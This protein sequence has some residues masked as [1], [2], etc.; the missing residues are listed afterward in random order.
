LI[1]NRI[2]LAFPEKEEKLF[3][4]KYYTDS[5]V[6]VRVSLVLVTILYGVFGYLDS[7]IFPEFADVFHIIRYAV[8]VPLLTVVFL[9]SFT[10]IFEKI[11]QILLFISL[12]AGGSG[13]SVMIMLVPDNYEYYAGLMLIFSA[14]YFFIK[15]RFF[16]ASIAGWLILIF[17]NI[18][19]IYYAQS[20]NLT[21]INT[22]F[23]FIS[24][25][26]IGMFAAYNIEYY[27][28][29]NFF[30]N[31]ELDNEKLV[32][33]NMNKNL[34]KT[35]DERTNELLLAKEAAEIN[36]ANVTAI[37]EGTQSNIWAFNRNYEILYIN[38]VF[39]KEFKQTFGVWLEPGV[40]LIDAL[41]EALRPLWKPRYDRVLQNEQFTVEDAIESPVGIIYIQVTFNPI[42]KKGEVIGGSCFGSDITERKLAELELK[43]AK[44]RAEESDRLKTA[45]LANM[46]HEIRTPMNGILGFAE[47]LKNPE[48]TGDEQKEFISIIEKSGARMLNII[49]DI[50]DISR[51]EAG[52]MQLDF[53]ATDINDQLGYIYSFFKPE[54][55]AKGIKFLLRDY[56]PAHECCVYT[57]REKSYAILINLVKNAIKYT[58]RGS[59]EFGC[60]RKGDFIEFYVQDTGI[61][62]PADR[63]D[64]IF[65][66]F[67][68]ADIADKMARQGAGLGLSI[69]KAYIEM[70]GGEIWVKSAERIGSSFYFTLPYNSGPVKK[71]KR[72]EFIF[73]IPEN[74]FYNED[75]LLKI[76]IAEDDETSEQLLTRAL[77]KVSKVIFKAT[78]GFEAVEIFRNNPDIDLIFM[79]LLMPGLN[80]FEATVQIRQLN[81][82]VVI[83]AQ[84][85]LGFSNDEQKAIE[86]GCNDYLVK[87]VKKDE[88]HSIIKKY[89]NKGY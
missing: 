51:I 86:A 28:R 66:R 82:H 34:G 46:S 73:E 77:N 2:T 57:D 11:W 39:Q 26:I 61:G 69:S 60:Y 79:D 84:T 36:N 32:V 48:L 8:V 81:K 70:L 74:D 6:Q 37:I 20:P 63:Q 18:G 43:R 30:L 59:I 15:L 24:S 33:L 53:R 3:L 31:Y 5:L 72:E 85:A 12:I 17:Y 83:I 35:V 22:N 80:G 64:A 50:V 45:F 65:E 47:L 41:P 4:S 29:R 25:N 75:H 62:I 40:S 55:E 10:R 13:I 42:V 68:Q 78:T 9:L 76:L 88:L 49:N 56:L 27:A 19:A 14:G 1:F 71:E 54:V 44:E 58:E 16:L 38:H 7:L 21:L 87:P 23:F 67:I 52:L 89:F